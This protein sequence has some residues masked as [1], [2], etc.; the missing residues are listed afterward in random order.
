VGDVVG[1]SAEDLT[2]AE[3]E[4]RRQVAALMGFVKRYVPGF[5]DSCLLRTAAQIGVR[6]TRR[7]IGEYVFGVEDIVSARKFD[8]AVARLAY[9]VDIHPGNGQ[10]YN[11]QEELEDGPVGPPAGDWYEIPYRCLLPLGVEN[12]LVAGRCISSTQESNSAIRIMPC[13][14][15]V[16]Q[17]AGT[18]AALSLKQDTTPRTLDRESLLRALRDQGALLR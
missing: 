9:P 16:G 12:L 11:R 2:R 8:D 3:I 17:A 7:I 5:E 6:E 18:A 1:T 13:C 14:A 15:A 10:G 4:G